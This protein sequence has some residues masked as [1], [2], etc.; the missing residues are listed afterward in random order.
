MYP[1]GEDERVDIYTIYPKPGIT[2]ESKKKMQNYVD[3]IYKQSE[4]YLKG[5]NGIVMLKFICSHDGLPIDIEIVKEKPKD[6]GF[7]EIAVEAIKLT[8][9]IPGYQNGKPVR[10]KMKMPIRFGPPKEDP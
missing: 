1:I 2:P 7:G 4:Y 8:K 6:C 3:S 9:F 10:V 5:I